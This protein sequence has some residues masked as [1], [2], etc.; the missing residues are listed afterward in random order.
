MAVLGLTEQFLLR[1]TLESSP[2]Y[3]LCLERLENFAEAMNVGD[4]QQDLF[5]V[6]FDTD[7]EED[8]PE[9]EAPPLKKKSCQG[10]ILYGSHL[11]ALR[12]IGRPSVGNLSCTM[13]HTGHSFD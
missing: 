8:D 2:H 7:D 13:G 3:T 11:T 12:S 6:G 1:R 9:V 10:R 5:G 4:R